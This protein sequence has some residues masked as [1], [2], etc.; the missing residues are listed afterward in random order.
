MP[1]DRSLEDRVTQLEELSSHQEHL[2]QQLNDV[3]VHL[4]T[5]FDVLLARMKSRIDSLEVRLNNLPSHDDPSE[6]PPHY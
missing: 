3:V 4:R 2:L 6:K 1:D 5:D